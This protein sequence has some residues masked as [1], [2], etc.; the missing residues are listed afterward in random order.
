MTSGHLVTHFYLALLGYINFCKAY[1]SCRQF[2]TDGDIVFLALKDAIDLLV[3]DNVVMKELFYA[4]VFLFISGPF[5]WID[6][7]KIYLL[8]LL[9][10]EFAAFRVSRQH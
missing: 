10:G 7:E 8:K 1:Y 3:L 9:Q 6:I 4:V 5:I 2:I